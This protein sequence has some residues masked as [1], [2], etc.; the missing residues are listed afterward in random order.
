MYIDLYMPIITDESDQICTDHFSNS[1]GMGQNGS[2]AKVIDKSHFYS[3]DSDFLMTLFLFL[4][5]Q[6][7]SF[8]PGLVLVL[9][10]APP[11]RPTTQPTNSSLLPLKRF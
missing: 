9:L 8:W 3:T 11:P 4:D 7:F 2:T 1:K 5:S 6:F 10:V